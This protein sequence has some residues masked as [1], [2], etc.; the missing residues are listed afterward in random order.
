MAAEIAYKITND[1]QVA[2]DL[3]AVY[4]DKLAGAQFADSLEAPI[5]RFENRDWIDARFASTGNQFKP[6]DITT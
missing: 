4:K 2:R 5:E 6:I 1:K 3:F